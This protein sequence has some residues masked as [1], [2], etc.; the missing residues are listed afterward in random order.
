MPILDKTTNRP[1]MS[2]LDMIQVYISGRCF[3]PAK[4]QEIDLNSCAG[5]SNYKGH[6]VNSQDEEKP[7]FYAICSFS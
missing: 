4:K 3:C 1:V 6:S 7:V 5:C 2:P